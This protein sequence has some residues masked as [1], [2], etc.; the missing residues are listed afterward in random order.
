VTTKGTFLVI[1]RDATAAYSAK[2]GLND[3]GIPFQVLVVPAAGV[4]LPALTSS[5]SVG[6][7]G[8]IVVLSEVSY[9]NAAGTY[10]SALTNDQWN[11]LYAYQR[12]FGVRMVRLDVVPSSAS[13]TK[14][15][16]SCC[17]AKVEQLVS[18][19]DTSLFPTAGLVR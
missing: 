13:G 16:G 9:P 10:V 14:A 7:F 1:A 19:N 18:I 2:S 3:Y 6:L 4:A 8:G 12:T 11:A 15:L 5:A 17:D